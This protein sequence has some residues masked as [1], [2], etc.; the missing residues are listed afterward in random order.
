ME[1]CRILEWDSEFFAKRIGTVERSRLTPDLVQQID[2]WRRSQR[3]DCLYLLA[4]PDDYITLRLATES[5]FR[6]VDVRVSLTLDRRGPVPAT[7]ASDGIAVRPAQAGEIDDLAKMARENHQDSRFFFDPCFPD[8]ACRRLYETWL[9]RSSD[10]Y[11]DA[12]LA[13]TLHGRLAGYVTLHRSQGG[14]EARIGLLGVDE[15]ARGQ[16]VGDALLTGALEWFITQGQEQVTVVTQGRN[17]AAQRLYQRH[18]FVTGSMSLW[19]HWW[20]S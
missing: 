1:P 9:L 13:A 6:L 5:G 15:K 4:D 17:L 14:E 8:E 2:I 16:H 10:G 7:A 11:A 20:R 3:V 12:V 19:Y 18:G